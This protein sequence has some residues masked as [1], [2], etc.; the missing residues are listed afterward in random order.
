M[1]SGSHAIVQRN[2]VKGIDGLH[3]HE[4]KN[5]GDLSPE[6]LMVAKGSLGGNLSVL[7]DAEGECSSFHLMGL[8]IC[9]FRR[10]A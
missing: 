9:G 5:S 10:L 6:F 1:L 3:S 4:E 8:H 7:L 2:D